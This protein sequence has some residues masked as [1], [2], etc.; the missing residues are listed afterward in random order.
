MTS[1]LSVA[2]P[3]P[4]MTDVDGQP[5]EDGYIFL[6]VAG[7][8]AEANPVVA[9]WD[10]AL[11]VPAAQPIRTIGGYPVRTGSPAV[12][13][14]DGDYSISVK[15]KN[16]TPIFQSLNTTAQIGALIGVLGLANGGTGGTT[17]ATALLGIGAL[18][19]DTVAKAGAYTVLTTD[20]GKLLLC[21][22]TWSL[23]LT[24]AATLGDGFSFGVV[25]VGS[26]VITIDPD[27][28]ELIDGVATLALGAGQSCFVTCTGAEF[29]SVGLSSGGGVSGAFYEND[30]TV[31]ADYTITSGKNAM[32]A[33][34][35]TI[36]SGVTVTVPSGSTWTIV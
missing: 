23:S 14:V 15:N 31:T 16:N 11:S 24:A 32:S 4:I 5:L 29:R 2:S 28:A 22:G 9:Y 18:A 7:L 10:A 35:I 34:P 17:Q 30:Q 6:G 12:V 3:F 33:G 1:P 27:A 21:D 19:S 36:S 13:Y 20:R 8:P 25:N 26:G